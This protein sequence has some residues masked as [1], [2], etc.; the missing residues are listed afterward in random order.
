MTETCVNVVKNHTTLRN[1]QSTLPPG[2]TSLSD[3]ES[4]TH[5][6][7]AADFTRFFVMFIILV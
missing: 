3:D 4:H 2:D 6:M 7:V 1:G 5:V